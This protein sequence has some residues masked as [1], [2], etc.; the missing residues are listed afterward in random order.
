M[1]NELAWEE[2]TRRLDYAFQPIVSIHT[3]NVFGLEALLRGWDAAGFSSIQALF[4]RAYDDQ[5]LYA[6]DLR[7]RKLALDKFS[8]SGLQ[9]SVKL[10]Y[11]LENRVLL[12]PDYHPGNTV[13][14][15]EEKKLSASSLCFEIS[16][17]HEIAC[18]DGPSN[19]IETYKQ[20]Q[21]RI[22]V[23][24]F[25]SGYSGL[26]LLYHS[27]PDMVKL[28]RFFIDGIE[29]DSKKK[30]FVANI[31]NMAHIMGIV[32]IAEGVETEAE[33]Y[34]CR[35]IGCDYVQG[36]LV[37]RPVLNLADLRPKY[38]VVESLVSRDKRCRE[39]S[40]DIIYRQLEFPRASRIEEPI[41]NV[42]ERFRN[43][44]K[45][46][47]I[48]VVNE[49]DE[50]LGVIR[51]RDLKH[52]VYSPFGISLL[53][54]HAYGGSLGPFLS[55]SPIAEIQTRVE[56]ILEAYAVNKEAEVVI[57]TENGRYKG[58]LNSR[59]LLQVLNE[60]EIAEARD[61]NPLSK[62]PGNNLIGAYIADRLEARDQDTALL[63]F[64]F[65]DF[66]PFNDLYGF[67]QGD[68]VILLF[69]DL[70]REEGKRH[71]WFVGHIGGDDFFAGAAGPSVDAEEV[72]VKAEEISRCFTD[73]VR[74]FYRDEDREL[75]Y[76]VSRSREGRKK[77]FPL[78]GVSV[79]LAFFPAAS[80]RLSVDEFS[81]LIADLKRQAKEAPEKIAFRRCETEAAGEPALR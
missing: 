48:P 6:L 40:Q 12:M 10:F 79:A 66:K 61:Q 76:I 35:E 34:V 59:S 5:Y 30:L 81:T 64:D 24:D 52:Y 18:F 27:Q 2:V 55:K 68:R 26:Q 50:P 13:R 9:G 43:D 46:A 63:Y 1:A 65:D 28:D 17:R 42:L 53:K 23:D 73:D 60:K 15:M 4:D 3:G 67:R 29:Q 8:L 75:G 56:K 62:L 51:E 54:N 69:A 14:L 7:L 74:A 36:Y 49:N 22:A 44:G 47:F 71:G 70:L 19:V 33:F 32:V 57:I 11:N 41:A 16:E 58:V 20:Q 77:K 37:Q 72:K 39:T 45:L 21:F 38:P 25:G 80:P 78:L 31:V